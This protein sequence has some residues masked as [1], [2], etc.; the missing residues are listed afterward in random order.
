[1]SWMQTLCDTYDICG[2]FIGDISENVKVPLL[3][4]YHS[5]QQIQITM[6]VDREGNLCP[7]YSRVMGPQENGTTI[8][9]STEEAASRSSNYVPYPLFDKMQYVAGDYLEYGG[10]EKRYQFPAYLQQLN[11]WCTSSYSHPRVC[12]VYQYVQK[13]HLIRDLLE[14]GIFALEPD[15]SLSPQWERKE[16]PLEVFVRFDV[17]DE[18][19]D[20]LWE[21]RD[22]RQSWIDYQNSLGGDSDICYGTGK[23]L[24]VSLSSPKKIRNAGDMTKLISAN[25]KDAFTFRGRF[26][27]PLEAACVG[28]ETTE[29]AHN[30]LRWLI[31]R[32]GTYLG[33]KGERV[34]V[35][36]I[37]D[38]KELPA[39]ILTGSTADLWSDFD[40]EEEPPSLGED[41]AGRFSKALKGYKAELQGGEKAVIMGLDA[42]TPGRLS[43]FYYREMLALDLLDNIEYWHTSC[44]W[45]HTFNKINF[46]GAP[47]PAQIAE[48]AYGAHADGNIKKEVAERLLPCIVERKPLPFDLMMSTAH[49]ASQAVWME[50]YEASKTRSVA[51]ALACKHY[52]D[53]QHKEVWKMS[54]DENN[55]DRSYLFGRLLAYARKVEEMALYYGGASPRFTNAEQMEMMFSRKP[56]TTYEILFKKLNPYFRRL[57]S[58]TTYY[59]KEMQGLVDRLY[60]AGFDDRP[61]TPLYL[62]GYSSQMMKFWEKKDSKT[63]ENANEST[64]QH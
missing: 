36:W 64:E 45:Y 60:A 20:R 48:A 24:P 7:G 19:M 33:S 53:I 50:P 10:E 9:P 56:M 15:G 31:G 28:K 47:S 4:L 5:T 12:A 34:F 41:F 8:V 52:N 23:V 21:D 25:D 51:C 16:N 54:L 13:G 6:V 27:T 1:M 32:Q 18:D 11:K 22:V 26:D 55:N 3:P 44:R 38:N 35:A 2:E 57:K 58:K 63:N 37:V 62:V 40:T 14:E 30:A 42:A 43:I 49:R 46:E 29:K 59:E 39:H 61:L 17:F